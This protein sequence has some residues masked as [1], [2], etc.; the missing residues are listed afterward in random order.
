[1]S[2]RP[3][4]YTQ[5]RQLTKVDEAYVAQTLLHATQGRQLAK[6]DDTYVA[7]TLLLHKD[8]S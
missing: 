3:C 4:C 2:L 6:G 8:D 7:Q 1:M 5:G